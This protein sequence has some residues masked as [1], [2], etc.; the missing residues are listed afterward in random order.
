V[1]RDLKRR[2]DLA[3]FFVTGRRALEGCFPRLVSVLEGRGAVWVAWPKKAS[4]VPSDLTE[5]VIRHRAVA[6][7]LVDIK[8]CAIDATWSGLRLAKRRRLDGS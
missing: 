7:G 6:G 8:V 3:L 1:R 4:G 5:D 2:P